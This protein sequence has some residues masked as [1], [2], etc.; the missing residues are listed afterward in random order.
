MMRVAEQL[1]RDVRG[2]AAAELALVTPLLLIIM[3]GSVELGN[4]FM[5]E[6]ALTKSVRDGARFAAR[7]PFTNYGGCAATAASVPSTL[8]AEVKTLVRKGS[9]D[10]TASD[11]LPNW[12]STDASFTVQ[13]KCSTS[14]G[15][16]TFGGIYQGNSVGTA[17]AGPVVIV[18]A[19]L[20][21]RPVLG[22]FGFTGRG[23]SLKAT[24]QAAVM[25]I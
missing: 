9:L 11:R 23:F 25:G 16:Q 6:H 5:S 18:S 19:T 8:S 15:T 20:P 17:N 10:A 14:V 3:F 22:S 13:M 21:Y 4:Y 2:A 7:R 24:Q 12:D 1:A